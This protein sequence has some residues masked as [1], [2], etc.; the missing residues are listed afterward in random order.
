MKRSKNAGLACMLVGA[1]V[2]TG[3]CMKPINDQYGRQVGREVDWGR[4]LAV[5]SVVAGAAG[6]AAANAPRNAL[7]YRHLGHAAEF[8][9]RAGISSLG[10]DNNTVYVDGNG[11][12]GGGARICAEAIFNKTL[13]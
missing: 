4:T 12:G 6:I 5:G 13:C 8:S 3:G 7:K 1:A 9:A 2:V 11:F 10:R